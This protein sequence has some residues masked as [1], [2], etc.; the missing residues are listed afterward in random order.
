MRIPCPNAIRCECSDLPLSNYSSADPDIFVYLSRFYGFLHVPLMNNPGDIDPGWGPPDGCVIFGSSP[1]SQEDADL[2]AV[3]AYQQC[4]SLSELQLACNACQA[5]NTANGA[6]FGVGAEVEEGEN[7]CCDPEVPED[8]CCTTVPSDSDPPPNN[9]PPDGGDGG[10]PNPQMYGND[11]QQ[12]SVSCPNGEQFTAN[13]GPGQYVAASKQLANEMAYS[14]A[15]RQAEKNRV[16]RDD[17]YGGGDACTCIIL[18]LGEDADQQIHALARDGSSLTFQIVDGDLP[19]G[20]TMDSTG[21]FSGNASSTGQANFK[22]KGTDKNGNSAIWNYCISVMGF[23]NDS[24]PNG[25]VGKAYSAQ[26]TGAGGCAPYNY[27]ADTALPSGLTLH[28]SGLIDGTPDTA[29]TYAV[30][31]NIND[32]QGHTCKEEFEINIYDAIN[33][34]VTSVPCGSNPAILIPVDVPAGKYHGAAGTETTL[35]QY[36]LADANNQA[37]AVAASYGCGCYMTSFTNNGQGHANGVPG[38]Q[39]IITTNCV[40]TYALFTDSAMTNP[41][42]AFGGSNLWKA[43]LPPNFGNLAQDYRDAN[44]APFDIQLWACVA[45]DPAKKVAFS[46][47]IWAP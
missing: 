8:C 47:H 32:A 16:C 41:L 2:C 43:T 34:A 33:D 10:P 36:A 14:A 26:L 22:V 12:C 39:S 5:I 3:S 29:G 30:I 25:G 13:V 45:T 28:T 23:G 31:F 27:T 18:C 19:D 42:N 46:Q 24:L 40:V 37:A 1:V 20:V 15:C 9:P 11:P 6:S 44:G 38:D 4:V 21:H 17:N 35:N 7:A